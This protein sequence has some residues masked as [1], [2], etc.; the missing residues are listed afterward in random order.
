[1]NN[2]PAHRIIIYDDNEMMRDSIASLLVLDETFEVSASFPNP[3]NVLKD[4]ELLKPA[5]ILMDIDMPGINGVEAVKIIRSVFY[6]LPVIMLTVFEDDDNIYQSICAGA[7]GYILKKTKPDMLIEMIKDVFDGGA[8]MTSSVAKKILQL[9]PKNT[10]IATHNDENLS[11][12]E[13]ELL[14]L[15]V[16]GKSYKMIAGELFI[17]IETVRTHIKKIYKKL[18][19]NSAT[20]AVYKAMAHKIV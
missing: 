13:V 2:T 6:D 17:S 7:S 15:L 11:K 16:L 18:Q 10:S 14:R 9:F 8:P 5:L 1:M 12:R 20:E 4:I 3:R 19:V